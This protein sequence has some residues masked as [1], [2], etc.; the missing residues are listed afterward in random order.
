[1]KPTQ[2]FL[3]NI[4]FCAKQSHTFRKITEQNLPNLSHFHTEQFVENPE[5]QADVHY[6][7]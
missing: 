7:I 1:M 5:K 6:Y 2:Y 4:T 3:E